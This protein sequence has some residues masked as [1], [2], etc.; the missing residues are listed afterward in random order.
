MA[1]SKLVDEVGSVALDKAG[2]TKSALDCL[3]VTPLGAPRA[4]EMRLLAVQASLNAS[5]AGRSLSVALELPSST[6]LAR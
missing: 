3:D 1:L 4:C 2:L 5:S 6:V